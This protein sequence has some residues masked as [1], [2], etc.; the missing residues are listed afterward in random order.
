MEPTGT[1]L[2]DRVQ[3]VAPRGSHHL[4]NEDLRVLSH[5]LLV[6]RQRREDAVLGLAL[7]CR[8]PD[9]SM[10]RTDR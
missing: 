6:W 5:Q 1:A 3:H 9:V 7:D 2:L 4:R 8:E 10:A